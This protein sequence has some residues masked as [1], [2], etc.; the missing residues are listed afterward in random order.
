MCNVHV[1][2]PKMRREGKRWLFQEKEQKYIPIADTAANVR[3]ISEV[4]QEKWGEG[5]GRT[6]V[7]HCPAA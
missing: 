3:Y 4:F 5:R 7:H 6:R 2:L 1:V